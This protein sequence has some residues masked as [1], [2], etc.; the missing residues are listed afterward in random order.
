MSLALDQ[1]R[2][3]LADV[4]TRLSLMPQAAAGAIAPDT[5][6]TTHDHIGGDKPPGGIDHQGDKT[7]EFRQKSAD[8]F[9]RRAA[10]CNTVRDYE[11][12]LID[13]RAALDA[14]QRTPLSGEPEWGSFAWRKQIALEV[15]AGTRTVDDARRFYQVSRATIYRYVA[16]YGEAA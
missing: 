16:Q 4:I 5:G 14:W 10:R 8:H 9:L 12:V 6:K 7:P 1:V 13:A 3:E 11:A 2:G 15:T